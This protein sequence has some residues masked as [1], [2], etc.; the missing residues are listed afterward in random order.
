MTAHHDLESFRKARESS[1]FYLLGNPNAKDPERRV[2]HASMTMSHEIHTGAV[3]APTPEERRRH[4]ID[5]YSGRAG[6]HRISTGKEL[7]AYRER[8]GR[9]YA[10]HPYANKVITHKDGTQEP[11]VDLAFRDWKPS[12]SQK[13][14][15]EARN[16]QKWESW[17]FYK[18]MG[19][20][21]YENNLSLADQHGT[22]EWLPTGPKGKG[23]GMAG[24]VVMPVDAEGSDGE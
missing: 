7:E 3:Y 6:D 4:M 10:G 13:A 2:P 11:S 24:N 1:R 12:Q 16:K 20:N 15:Y 21:P 17:K 22:I 19:V 23:K 14:A 9:N 18:D 8:Y 5:A